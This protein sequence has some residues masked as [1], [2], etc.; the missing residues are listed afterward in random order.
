[1][2][3]RTQRTHWSEL[4]WFAIVMGI[5][6]TAG[7]LCIEKPFNGDDALFLLGARE[8][9][10]GSVLYVDFWDNKQPGIY[11]F[12]YIAGQ[13]FGFNE[14]G[15]HLFELLWLLAFSALCCLALREYFWRSWLAG[16]VPLVVVG[17]YYFQ[18]GS[19]FALEIEMLVALPMLAC[20]W[21]LARPWRTSRTLTSGFVGA[22]GLAAVCVVFKLAFAPL[23]IVFLLMA[24]WQHRRSDRSIVRSVIRTWAAF[25][26]GVVVTLG[27]VALVFAVFGALH[28][29]LWSSFVYPSLAFREISQGLV[30]A[31]P[32]SRLVKGMI[33][34]LAIFAPWLPFIVPALF[35][36]RR[37]DEPAEPALSR[38]MLIWL[39]GGM[40]IIVMQRFSWWTY[41]FMLLFTPTA[42]LCV[43]G[44]DVVM[45]RA[46]TFLG[47]DRSTRALALLLV[48]PA[49]LAAVPPAAEEL[50]QASRM[51]SH[52]P[53]YETEYAFYH[54]DSIDRYHQRKS[55]EYRAILPIAQFL[56]QPD[57][58]PGPIYIIGNPL[59]YLFSG[60]QQA[61]PVHGWSWQMMT[62]Q[63]WQELPKEIERFR[64][65]YVFVDTMFLPVIEQRNPAVLE[66]ILSMYAVDHETPMGIWYRLK[67]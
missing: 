66:T 31:A 3:L 46:Q 11:L 47:Q 6:A 39:I 12:F 57:S 54:G 23:F 32:V 61:L 51:W 42:V 67:T 29:L 56:R 22:G 50:R 38:M 36:M 45:H 21:L 43:R 34:Y 63:Q 24:M 65:V 33:W 40:A 1:M 60:R 20:V 10:H 25:T 35:G 48:T 62:T 58:L 5:V 55:E 17:S 18:V 59:I 37:P 64:P 14:R 4:L 28:A 53:Y 16:V 15:V 27:V 8:M 41:H 7:L 44:I 9:A 49:L 52:E 2:I 19:E 30:P 26:L 13:L